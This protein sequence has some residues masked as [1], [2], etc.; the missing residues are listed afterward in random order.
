MSSIIMFVGDF[1]V[2]LLNLQI[3]SSMLGLDLSMGKVQETN[4]TSKY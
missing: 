4:L 2:A 3:Q 1:G